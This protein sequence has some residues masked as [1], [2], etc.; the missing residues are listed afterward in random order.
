M[1]VLITGA[2]GYIGA[3]LAPFLLERGYDVLGLDTGFYREGWLYN[4]GVAQFPPC[5]NKDIRHMT[6]EDVQGCDAVIHLNSPICYPRAPA[7]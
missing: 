3:S 2:E 7:K 5:I 1:K 4:N 6:A